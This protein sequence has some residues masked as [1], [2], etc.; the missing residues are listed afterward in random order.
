MFLQE[1]GV[2]GLGRTFNAASGFA[3]F[4]RMSLGAAASGL[5]F[6]WG[7]SVMLRVLK[8]R[9]NREENVVEVATSFTMAYLTYFVTEQVFHCSG[10]IGTL[11]Y[12]VLINHS[13]FIND[14]KLMEDFWALV[15]FLLNTVLFTLGG[16]VW[17]EI[18][19][20][21]DPE[22]QFTGRDWGY[23]FVLYIFLMLI[24]LFL[25][26]TCYPITASIGLGTNLPETLFASFAGLRG[27]V[28]IALAIALDNVVDAQDL[29]SYEIETNRLFGFVGG[30]AF[31]TL[32]LNA[33]LSGPL[34]KKL[35]LADK[36]VIREKV[37]KILHWRI[38]Q[39]FID[40]MV[41][42]LSEPRFHRVNF[43]VVRHHLPMIQDLTMAELQAAVRK[44]KRP[45]RKFLARNSVPNLSSITQYI[46]KTE[47]SE[48][49]DATDGVAEIN[50]LVHG[51]S[52][53]SA[54]EEQL[55]GFRRVGTGEKAAGTG[56]TPSSTAEGLRS[57]PLT[58]VECRRLFLEILRA[59]YAF[60]VEQGELVDRDVLVHALNKSLDFASVD[61]CKGL[62][63][64]DWPHTR[65]ARHQN[66][67]LEGLT[68]KLWSRVLGGRVARELER[69][70][71][72]YD[73]D[74]CVSF[75][76]AHRRSREVFKNEFVADLDNMTEAEATV[77][78]DSA[79]TCAGAVEQLESYPPRSVETIVSHRFC[80]ILLNVVV[81]HVEHLAK[82]GLLSSKEAEDFLGEI[83][84]LILGI[85]ACTLEEHP[86][87]LPVPSAKEKDDSEGGE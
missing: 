26:F 57:S 15:E 16:L 13:S 39:R 64:D 41:T 1:F 62:P 28:G 24:R 84:M 75:L 76:E 30:I 53:E 18:I 44:F 3:V 74:R 17:G 40:D 7:T 10:V 43:A 25:L 27:A 5:L 85:E 38:R 86:G 65:L 32:T 52:E 23:L 31:L 22:K 2:P 19:A 4:F 42:L 73:V 11:T 48:T 50:E 47:E 71:M 87:E 29:S 70:Q 72:K 80:T 60:Q 34:L 54:R 82:T 21:G 36:P 58:L 14:P 79:A 67:L 55:E 9:L 68:H 51:L 37:I 61:V 83:E 45:K 81:Q 35:G 59:S 20:N 69:L 56:A 8:R 77:L 12:G 63:L 49:G 66:P 6:G 78:R 46:L 33:T